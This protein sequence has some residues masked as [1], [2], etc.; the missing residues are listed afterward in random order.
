[1]QM[2]ATGAASSDDKTDY[3][4]SKPLLFI[5]TLHLILVM[6]TKISAESFDKTL[7]G[8]KSALYFLNNNNNTEIAI[9]N[10]G[11]RIVSL[12]VQD[13]NKQPTDV[14][15]G[16]DTLAGSLNSTETYHGAVVGRYANRIARGR[17][18]LNGNTYELSINN[19]PNHLHGGSKGFNNQVWKVQEIKNQ[20][21]NFPIFQNMVKK[22]I[23][24]I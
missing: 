3:I 20:S 14:V 18:S 8:Q 16:F 6:L 13:K 2:Y 7:N 12:I 10:Y 22:I 21:L 11:A 19:P 24:V 9:T 23:L 17:F 15:V 5:C 1:M 4:Y